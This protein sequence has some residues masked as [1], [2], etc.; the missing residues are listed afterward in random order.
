MHSQSCQSAS[1]DQRGPYALW[2]RV[3]RWRREQGHAQRGRERATQG[4]G[5]DYREP[6]KARDPQDGGH[7]AGAMPLTHSMCSPFACTFEFCRSLVSACKETSART[8][9]AS[10]PRRAGRSGAKSFSTRLRAGGALHSLRCLQAKPPP[11]AETTVPMQSLRISHSRWHR[12]RAPNRG[13]HRSASAVHGCVVRSAKRNAVVAMRWSQLFERDVPLELLKDMEIQ[14]DAC[15][16]II[17]ARARAR[18][19]AQWH[20][21]AFCRRCRS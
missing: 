16:R 7:P 21:C 19:R 3:S 12:W 18:R 15:D 20:Q 13:P 2:F 8:S 17:Q 11:A 9:G 1:R 10:R 6:A 14:K 5:S 4:E